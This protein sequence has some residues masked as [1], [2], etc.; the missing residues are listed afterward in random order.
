MYIKIIRDMKKQILGYTDSGKAVYNVRRS[1]DFTQADLLDAQYICSSL[2][3][4][5]FK[6]MRSFQKPDPIGFR[7]VPT[8]IVMYTQ[9]KKENDFFIDLTDYFYR[10]FKAMQNGVKRYREGDLCRRY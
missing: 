1:K 3:D 6:A 8:N 5:K 9:L 10:K 2:A 7:L 4:K